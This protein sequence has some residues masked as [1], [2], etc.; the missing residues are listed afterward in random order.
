MN[1]I[2]H[3]KNGKKIVEVNDKN[4]TIQNESDF[5]D[6][7]ANLPLN[8][9]IIHKN[10]LTEEFFD[11]KTGIAGNILQK[12][13]NYKRYLGIIGDFSNITSKS[14][15]DFIFESNKTKQV[16]FKEKLKEII[17]IFSK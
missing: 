7:I 15:R 4:L 13:S 8:K 16:V 2:I 5:L 3:E 6:L 17:E 11:L 12:V 1:F 9:I 14:V 10:N